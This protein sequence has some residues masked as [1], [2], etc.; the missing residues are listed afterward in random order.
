LTLAFAAPAAPLTRA[1][2]AEYAPATAAACVAS[3][4]ATWPSA[5]LCAEAI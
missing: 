4:L 2:A 1:C 3:E 5:E